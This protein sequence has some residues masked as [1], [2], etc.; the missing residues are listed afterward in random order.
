MSI[1]SIQGYGGHFG[2][3][4]QNCNYCEIDSVDLLND[5]P[6][7]Q[8]TLIRIYHQ[9]HLFPPHDPSP[10]TCPGCGAKFESDGDVK[11]D[12]QP[13]NMIAY[14]MS[15]GGSTWHKPPLLPLEPHSA[16]S[17]ARPSGKN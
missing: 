12:K 5:V 8:R 13:G 1:S 10:F 15:H 16:T 11:N 4:G 9:C 7:V 6:A 17:G 14:Q 2:R 3:R